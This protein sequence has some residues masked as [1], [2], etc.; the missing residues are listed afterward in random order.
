[1]FKM[2]KI[3]EKIIFYYYCLQCEK[4]KVGPINSQ[5][6]N[7]KLGN[8]FCGRALSSLIS[9]L[10][11]KSAIMTIGLANI[12]TNDV[13][14]ILSTPVTIRAATFRAVTFRSETHTDVAFTAVTF[15]AVT[16]TVVAFTI[17]TFTVVTF[18]GVAFMVVAFMIVNF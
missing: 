2:D 13:R 16:F 18:M 4:Q 11:P 3:R 17:V 1:M 12:L 14:S 7:F 10:L 8:I 6:K 9:M 5:R 15:R